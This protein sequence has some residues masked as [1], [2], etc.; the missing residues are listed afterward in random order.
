MSFNLPL[1]L[2]LLTIGI[3]CLL[4]AIPQMV[5]GVEKTLTRAELPLP[6]RKILASGIAGQN[7]FLLMAAVTA[8]VL[9]TPAAE[10]QAPVLQA[11]LT[12]GSIWSSLKPQ[13]LPAVIAGFSSVILFI[14]AY[15]LFFL[16]QLDFQTVWAVEN[17][18][19]YLNL[20]G[21]LFYNGIMEEIIARWGLMTVFVW[22]GSLLPGATSPI[23]VW[24]AIIT[25]GIVFA[26]LYLPD[27]YAAGS[28]KSRPFLAFVIFMYLWNAVVFG[29]L[30]WQ[31]GWEAAIIAH[32]VFLLIWYP[33]DMRLN[34]AK[35][36]E[37]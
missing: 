33:Y 32:M 17:Q 37:S 20:W 24:L 23:I 19:L 18:R 4:V 16:P 10:L 12:G 3:L 30:F 1:A 7:L 5:K 6:S 31:Y 25:G 35:K 15:Y 28:K 21:R 34:I 8:G 27:Y 22:L 36:L 11:I 9:L 13:L 26:L 14:L 29:W 2:I